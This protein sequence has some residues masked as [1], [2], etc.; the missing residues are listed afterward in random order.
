MA[1]ISPEIEALA[2]A[3]SVAVFWQWNPKGRYAYM[4]VRPMDGVS[5]DGY[6]P[7]CIA[8]VRWNEGKYEVTVSVGTANA[9]PGD[10]S[11]PATAL[12]AAERYVDESLAGKRALDAILSA[13]REWKGAVLEAFGSEGFDKVFAI[14]VR[15]DL[16][17]LRKT[18]GT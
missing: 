11:D 10:F 18:L 3:T 12:R 15:N 7:G 16:E 2:E 4:T 5:K 6:T 8:Y 13:E 1:R 14:K 9:C 17:A